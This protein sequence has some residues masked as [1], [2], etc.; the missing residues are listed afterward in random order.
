[1]T[2]FAEPG[3]DAAT[4]PLAD[5]SMLTGT[6]RNTSE[7]STGIVQITAEAVEGILYVRF[8]GSENGALIDW[9]PAPATVFFDRN[10]EG[11]EQ[12]FTARWEPRFMTVIAQGFLRQGVLVILTFTRFQDGSSRS[13]YFSKEF[14][15]RT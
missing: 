12:P 4:S 14:F 5:L 9:G 6:W 10:D 7:R 2:L 11:M 8:F 3:L 13:N 1:M 15:T